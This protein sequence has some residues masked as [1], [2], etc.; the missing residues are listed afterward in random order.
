MRLRLPAYL[1]LVLCLAL[2]SCDALLEDTDARCG[3]KE[4]IKI[5]V[6][7]KHNDPG[8]NRNVDTIYLRAD[9]M[10]TRLEGTMRRF[11]VQ[12]EILGVCTHEHATV[13]FLA[14]SKATSQLPLDVTARADWGLLYGTEI[15]LERRTTQFSVPWWF[16]ESREVEIGLKQVYGD[17]PGLYVLRFDVTFPTLGSEL[18][19]KQWLEDAFG[20]SS[21]LT[22]TYFRHKE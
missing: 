9:Q 8:H 6:I 14:S 21:V 15:P 2:T 5:E 19:D 16:W 11:T 10:P 4:E 12:S 13:T 22:T 18:R 3:P 1:G 7:T 17:G 20:Y